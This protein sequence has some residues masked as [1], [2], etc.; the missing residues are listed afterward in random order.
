MIQLQREVVIRRPLAE[1]FAFI[2]DP[3]K[4]RLWNAPIVATE[5]AMAVPAGAGTVFHHTVE[6]MG[7]RFTTTGRVVDY[8]PDNRACVE[9][10]S[11]PL[12]STG[13]RVVEETPGG[14]RLIVTLQGEALGIFKL[15]ERMAARAAAQ[16]LDAALIQLKALLEGGAAAT[17]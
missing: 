16:Q 7:R 1:V 6:F 11:G 13:C 10:T 17:G 4:D 15:G 3:A 2:A 14:T 8:V 5:I 9:T 12:R